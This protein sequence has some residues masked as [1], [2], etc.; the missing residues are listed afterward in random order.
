MA[1]IVD[2]GDGN[3]KPLSTE[4]KLKCNIIML[5]HDKNML[6]KYFQEAIQE[7]YKYHPEVAAAIDKKVKDKNW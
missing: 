1:Y 2:V 5:E 7:L 4:Q 3:T 6:N